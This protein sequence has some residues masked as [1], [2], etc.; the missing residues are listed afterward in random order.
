MRLFTREQAQALDQISMN[1]MGIQGVTLMGNAGQQV[2]KKAM[3]L[4]T[5]AHDP[6]ILIICGQGN[7]GGDG[8]GRERP[9]SLRLAVNRRTL[10]LGSLLRLSVRRTAAGCR[11]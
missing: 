4:L 11:R 6:S 3:A 9:F 8:L 7:N 2:A 10:A 1:E 5:E